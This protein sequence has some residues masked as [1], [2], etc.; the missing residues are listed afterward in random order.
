MSAEPLA[1]VGAGHFFST[2]RT[3]FYS[4]HQPHGLNGCH[5]SFVSRIAS[6]YSH[7]G[8]PRIPGTQLLGIPA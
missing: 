8:K 7:W 5:G 6:N 4:N 1:E 3:R 2:H